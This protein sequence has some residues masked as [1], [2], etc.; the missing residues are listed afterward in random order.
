MTNEMIP[1]AGGAN[2]LAAWQEPSARRAQ[3]EIQAAIVI[4]KANPRN[5]DKARERVRVACQRPEFADASFYSYRRGGTDITD[6]NVRTAELLAQAWGNVRWGFRE[7]AREGRFSKLE[8]FAWDCESN[9][10]AT[11]EIMVK[12]VRDTKGGEAPL[13]DE[14]DI[15]ENNASQAQR[16]VRSLLFQILPIDYVNM[17]RQELLRTLEKQ[18]GD[19]PIID[20]ARNAAAFFKDEHGVGVGRILAY[21]RISKL[22]EITSRHLVTLRQIANTLKDGESQV[23]DI[24]PP[25]PKGEVVDP[26][27]PKGEPKTLDAVVEKVTSKPVAPP[28]TTQEIAA[29]AKAAPPAAEPKLDPDAQSDLA[30][31]VAKTLHKDAVRSPESIAREKAA[32]AAADP[33]PATKKDLF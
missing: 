28:K 17:A 1:E 24:F 12:H 5:E 30:A 26:S 32:L 19:G 18:G 7:V 29:S 33:K 27:A 21:F 6:L 15:R 20:K 4:A 10:Y 23:D 9:A 16:V 31:A 13:R 8:V 25:E 2:A 14:R 3:A 22:D 11:R